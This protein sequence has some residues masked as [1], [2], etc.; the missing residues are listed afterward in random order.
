MLRFRGSRPVE[1]NRHLHVLRRAQFYTFVNIPQSN[2]ID[3]CTFSDGFQSNTNR[4]LHCWELSLVDKSNCLRRV[5]RFPVEQTTIVALLGVV[6]AR[7]K[8]AIHAN[9]QALT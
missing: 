3:V 2:E 6:S 7:M 4:I 5:T 1:Q 9:Q 8:T